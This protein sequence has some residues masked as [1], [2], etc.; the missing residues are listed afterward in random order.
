LKE[1]DYDGPKI[2][3]P[4]AESFFGIATAQSADYLLSWILRFAK[5]FK[6]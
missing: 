2:L 1:S 4:K 3:I 5:P 6:R